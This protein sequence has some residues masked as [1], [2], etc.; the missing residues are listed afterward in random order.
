M[1]KAYIIASVNVT[2]PQKYE[3]YKVLSGPAMAA[4][5]GR[6][7]VRGGQMS[8]LEGK[9]EHPRVVVLEFDS[10]A[11]AKAAYDSPEYLE[12][13]RARAGAAEFNMIVIEG[14]A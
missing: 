11:Q 5:G 7:V 4:N 1:A 13:R 14:V 12:A 9:W 6:F 10:Y 2:D 3:D 8:V